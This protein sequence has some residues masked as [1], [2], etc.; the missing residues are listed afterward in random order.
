MASA[1][2]TQSV[3]LSSQ[4][5]WAAMSS[6]MSK[7]C[8]TRVKSVPPARSARILAETS[9]S[10]SLPNGQAPIFLPAHWS[11]SVMPLSAQVTESVAE[12]WKTWA[13]CTRS[14][15]DS[16][17]SSTFGTQ[18]M[19]NSGPSAADPTCCGTTSPPPGS[20]STV[21]FSSS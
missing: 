20:I 9:T 7:S 1:T 12:R 10:S 14:E 19:V 18:A 8:S 2:S 15:P 6:F 21:R 11:T 5:S 17:A 3:S 16:R 4:P 13:I